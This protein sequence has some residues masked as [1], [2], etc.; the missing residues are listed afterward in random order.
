[1]SN[2]ALFIDLPNFY[3]RL[4]KSGIESPRFLRDYFLQWLDFDL[5]A[6]NLTLT[7]EFGF[8]ILV[9]VSGHLVSG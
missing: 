6:S 5:L 8:S 2:A 4:L 7:Q 9:N 3:S 1:M